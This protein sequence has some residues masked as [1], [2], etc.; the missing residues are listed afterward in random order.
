MSRSVLHPFQPRTCQS[1]SAYIRFLPTKKCFI[2]PKP[3]LLSGH[4]RPPHQ[5]LRRR[6]DG[7]HTVCSTLTFEQMALMHSLP[8]QL[9]PAR[10]NCFAALWPHSHFTTALNDSP[11][12]SSTTKAAQ[13]SADS[14]C[15]R[16]LWVLLL[17]FLH[18]SPCVHL[19]LCVL[20]FAIERSSWLGSESQRSPR[21]QRTTRSRFHQHLSSWLMSSQLWRVSFLILLM[22]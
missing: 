4:A 13:R 22:A 17:T 19:S 15:Y 16:T 1:R 2:T 20:S 6:S 18:N 5:A 3:F 8:V 9:V 12:C 7:W 14:L 10:A 21:P 11:F